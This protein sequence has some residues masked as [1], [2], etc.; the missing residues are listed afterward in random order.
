[1]ISHFR[2]RHLGETGLIIGNGPS[3]QF[4]PRPFID[5]YPSFGQN[6]CY[7]NKPPLVDFTP[8]YYVTSD[9]DKDIDYD[10][11]MKY[12]CPKFLKEGLLKHGGEF[13]HEFK[14]TREHI[15]SKH[16]DIVLYEGYSVTFISLQLAYYMGFNTVLLIGVDH[17]YIPYNSETEKDP[18]HYHSDYNGKTDFDAKAL[19]KGE[20]YILESMLLAKIAYENDGKKI[21][22]LTDNSNLKVFEFD[23]VENWM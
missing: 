1:V 2:N 18:N 22:N 5:A 8:S 6:K 4:I 21:I 12:T 9:P 3:L 16:P 13:V 10:A 23:S 19:A 14:L 20:K 7:L 17:R 11:V 15:F